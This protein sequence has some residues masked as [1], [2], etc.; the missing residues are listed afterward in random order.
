LIITIQ[1][2][3]KRISEEE[4]RRKT[5][6]EEEKKRTIEEETKRERRKTG[7]DG[8]RIR[9]YLPGGRKRKSQ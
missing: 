6:T 9:S 5:I 2:R 1:K 3:W 4:K 8:K 7:G